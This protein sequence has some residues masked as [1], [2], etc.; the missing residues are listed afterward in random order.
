MSK[1]KI[2]RNDPCPC[3]S[4]KKY[5]KC[6]LNKT[7]EQ[8]YAEAILYAIDDIKKAARIKQ[9]L[10][11][12]KNE[13]SK[14]IVKAHAIQNNRILNKICQDG[15]VVTM[16]GVS[17]YMFQDSDVKGRGIATV[18]TGFCSYHDKTLFQEI[19]DKEFACSKKQIFLLTYRT[20]AWHYHK[21]QEQANSELIKYRKMKEK[22]YDLSQSEDYLDYIRAL[23]RGLADN[24][25][26]KELF[27]T[28]LLSEDYDSV[29]SW[30]WEIPYELS[31]AVSMMTELE[32][33]LLGNQI[34]DL[35]ADNHLKQLYLNIFPANGK[36]YCIWS[37][38]CKCD[39]V[40]VPFVNQFKALNATDRQNYL[41]NNLPRW[42]DSL[43]ISPRLWN[44]WGVA[45]QEAIITHANF[46]ILY[47]QF[48][49]EDNDFSYK[50]MDTPWNLFDTL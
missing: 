7:Q 26:E 25:E 3:G 22:G 23:S 42:S 24:D 18:F 16:D 31:F 28:A 33:D 48:E 21:K 35:E 39:G 29:N 2:G 9:C 41:N 44:K 37:W 4:G 5:K 20:L 19:E 17:H 13:C 14:K 46:D 40:Y 47:R 11:P 49:E 32:H 1:K 38:N 30:I 12:N 27:D 15:M 34:N 8:C 6:C 36:S 45:I 50:F 43:V 10:H